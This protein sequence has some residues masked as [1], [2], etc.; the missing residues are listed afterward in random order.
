MRKIA[1]AFAIGLLAAAGGANV[2]VQ[3]AAAAVTSQAKV[4][5]VV[6][7]TQGTT[8]S[9][10]SDADAAAAVFAKYTSNIV[11]VYSPYATWSAVQNA[12][13][14]ANVL[15]YMG[16]GSGYPNPYVSYL[17]PNADN[18][19]G[20]NA[21]AGN[22]DS[23][24]KYYGQ[25]YMAQL[26]LTPNALVLLNHL[27]YASGDNEWGLGNPSFSTA[28]T[29]ID[30]YAS[31]FLS[32][33]ARAVIAEGLSS[34]GPYID[35]LFTTNQTID[36]MWKTYPG[37]NNH[38]SSWASSQNAGMTSQMDPSLDHPA[39]D[40]DVYYRSLVSLPGLTTTTVRT[41][42]LVASAPS[43]YHAL[44][45]TRIL[46]TRDGTG[47]LSGRFNSPI[48]RTFQVTGAGG[49]PT[50][51]SAVTGNLTVTQQSSAGYLFMGPIA[52]NN[53]SSST[54]NF[55]VGDNRANAV[56]VA[57]GTGG[58][59]S[60]TFI[61]ASGGS[62]ST[63]VVVDVTGYFTPDTTG[64]TYHALTPTRI[65]D[66][67]DGTG[68]LSGTFSSYVARTFHVTGSGGV[69]AG[70][71]AVTGNLTVTQ[72]SADG[73]LFIGPVAAN[74]PTSST[75]NFPV[76]DNRANAVAVALG[77]GSALG[78]LSITYVA[79][80]SGA[81]T[82]VVFDVTGYF[83]QD[84]TGASF[85]PLLPIR[86]L[87]SRD[88]TGGLSGPFNAYVARTFQMT[89]AG[90]V[91][92]GAKAITGNLTVTQQ[93]SAGILFMGPVA[94]NNPTSSTLNFP[95]GDNRAN[96]VTVALGSGGTLSV[97]YVGGALGATAQ[98]VFDVS[99]Y[100]TTGS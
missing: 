11:K 75:L 19:M 71:V 51:A 84:A 5:I 80:P 60:V 99:G 93:T 7:A 74:N 28:V 23:N 22:G 91:P 44:T 73:Y 67:R 6:G 68:G 21:T 9:Y 47:G 36:Q 48:A 59:L 15:V 34:L 16:H 85:V 76:G 100:F 14:G 87:D 50:G 37:F 92:A 82:H 54:L 72:Q 89:G 81:T 43:T 63:D 94:T 77:T 39:S 64:A 42:S 79:G 40:G 33:N 8:A 41:S 45:P 55:P 58:T 97:T 1:I 57:L 30:G 18:G 83:T 61:A 56:T 49:V 86:V 53:P 70:A 20:L 31:G 98:V 90:G 96:G 95:V 4:V 38:V 62:G 69:P 46:D 17:Q 27:C 88:G 24:T 78:T 26:N 66:S 25:N 52:T 10:R 35:A 65:L 13:Q 32:G 3:P 2:A 12:A 29:R